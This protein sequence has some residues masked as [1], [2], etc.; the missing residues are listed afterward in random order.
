MEIQAIIID[1]EQHCIDT[2]TWQINKYTKEVRVVA[3]FSSPKEAIVYLESNA[4]DL[5]FLDIEMPEMNGFD[6]LAQV[7]NIQFEVIFATAYDEFAI[8][9]FHAS[10]IDYLLKPIHKDLLIASIAKVRKKKQPKILPEQM[11]IL[12]GALNAKEPV[13]ERIAVPTQEGLHFVRVNEILYCISDSNYTFIYLDGG[14]QL[15]VSKTL[16]EIEAMLP[17]QSFLRIHHSHLINFKKI[18]KY[19]RGDGGYVIMDDKKSLSVS[20]SRKEALLSKF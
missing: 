14:K 2:L 6:F 18:E 16:K 4:I 3:A 1:D 19:I 7:Q 5:V 11:N 12:Y 9:A 17:V 20:R 8:K 10:A 15:L 13:K